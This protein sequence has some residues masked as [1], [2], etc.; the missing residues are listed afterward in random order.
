MS[1]LDRML[2]NQQNWI[3]EQL[4]EAN[5]IR[6]VRIKDV[7]SIDLLRLVGEKLP[8]IK[9][10]HLINYLNILPMNLISFN[11]AIFNRLQELDI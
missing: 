6:E 4:M 2:M 10:P 9:V 1:V 11:P 8:N 7:A 5:P 3:F